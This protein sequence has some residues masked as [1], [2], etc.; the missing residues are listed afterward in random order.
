[1]NAY[2]E[3]EVKENQ[4]GKKFAE[5]VLRRALDRES[6]QSLHLVLTA[7]DGGEPRRSGTAQ[8]WINVTDANDNAPVFAQD[9]YQASLYEDAPPGASVL[10]VS[11]SDSDDGTNAHITYSFDKVT[12]KVLRQFG[13]QAETGIITLKEALDFEDTR[14]YTLLVEARD[15]GGLATHCKVEVEVLDVNDNAP[16]IAI[17]SVVSTIPEDSPPDTVVALVNVHDADSGDNGK[18]WCELEGESPL[19]IVASSGSSYKVVTASA[20]DRERA[21]E[22]NVTVPTCQIDPGLLAWF[23]AGRFSL[24][25]PGQQVTRQ[26]CSQGCDF[27]PPA[28]TLGSVGAALAAVLCTRLLPTSGLSG[29]APCNYWPGLYVPLSANDE[30]RD[31]AARPSSEPG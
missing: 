29:R 30:A 28:G 2:F 8:V 7:V 22:H 12:A 31:L 3:V 10:Q 4:D 17:L 11:A 13:L 6:E 9:R 20:L 5:L 18:V 26:L 21:S 24:S 15:G 19:S 27:C 25:A 14:G 1:A 16:E 23:L